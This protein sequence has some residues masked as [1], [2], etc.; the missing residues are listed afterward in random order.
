MKTLVGKRGRAVAGGVLVA[1]LMAAC[2]GTQPA[3]SA[4][5]ATLSSSPGSATVEQPTPSVSP[6]PSIAVSESAPAPTSSV[7]PAPSGATAA[8][9]SADLS[10]TAVNSGGGLGT[11]GGSLR[12]QNVGS[13][14]CALSGWPEMVGVTEAGASSIATHT[15]AV[16]DYPTIVGTPTVILPP[17]ASAF[18]AYAG[19]DTPT[20]T[21][22]S[23]PPPYHTLEVTA[24]GTTRAVAIPA[25]NAWFGQ[26]LPSCVGIEVT[27][28]VAATLVPSLAS[29]RP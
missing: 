15:D 8:C 29:L 19:G 6:L 28:V 20:G 4:P 25:Y 23:C 13:V 12:F 27:P 22:N 21:S 26:D 11:I 2:S 1:A 18:A 5:T 9:A 3:T 14:P 24:P 7:A 10:V 16:L 17:G